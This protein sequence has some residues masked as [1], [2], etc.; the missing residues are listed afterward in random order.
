MARP[1]RTRPMHVWIANPW[2]RGKRY[3]YSWRMHNPQF[4]VYGKR[5]MDCEGEIIWETENQVQRKT[6]FPLFFCLVV[7]MKNECGQL[8]FGKAHAMVSSIFDA[9]TNE[10]STCGY[11]VRFYVVLVTFW[12][13]SNNIWKDGL[14]LET[15]KLAIDKFSKQS[16][17]YSGLVTSYG[18]ID[19]GQHCLR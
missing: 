3:R 16:L 5:P 11:Q 15:T 13:L 8:C 6:K 1:W 9:W 4:Y 2:W 7:W 14:I 12:M 10:W 17:T 18:D 19:L